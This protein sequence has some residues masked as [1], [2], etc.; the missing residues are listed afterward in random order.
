VFMR[1]PLNAVHSQQFRKKKSV[2]QKAGQAPTVQARSSAGA[3]TELPS[4]KTLRTRD[5][6]MP[7]MHKRID[8]ATA[9]VINEAIRL[10]AA[11]GVGPAAQYLY[12]RCVP[13]WIAHRVLIRP[14]ARRRMS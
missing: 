1:L 10:S 5:G 6:I 11:A 13:V 7:V 14:A 3:A 4:V 12:S 2:P 9:T 8:I